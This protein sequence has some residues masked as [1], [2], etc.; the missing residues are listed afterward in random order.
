MSAMIGEPLPQ[1][2]TLPPAW[3]GPRARLSLVREGLGPVRI[4]GAWWPR[5]PDLVN[6]LPPLLAALAERWGY[7]THVTVDGSMWLPGASAMVLGGRTLR[8]IRSTSAGHR[9]T[10]CLLIRGVGRC[11]LIVVPPDAPEYQA[12]RLMAATVVR[13]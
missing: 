2:L 7:I 1:P 9:H 10:A 8:I 11:D 4:D 13:Y 12:R 5:S 3:Q 6:E